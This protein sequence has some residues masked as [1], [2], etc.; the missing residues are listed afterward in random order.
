MPVLA[1]PVASLPER[2]AR[3]SWARSR[4]VG[5]LLM[6]RPTPPFTV[7]S[8][9]SSPSNTASSSSTGI[10]T[11]P[12]IA[13]VP[14]SSAD[15]LLGLDAN[16]STPHNERRKNLASRFVDI[17]MSPRKLAGQPTGRTLAT[18][19]Q[20]CPPRNNC[21]PHRART[22]S[23][24]DDRLGSPKQNGPRRETRAVPNDTSEGQL[25]PGTGTTLR[26]LAR[27]RV[28]VH[29]ARAS[30]R[31]LLVRLARR[32]I[33]GEDCSVVERD[34]HAAAG[35]PVSVVLE[36]E[37]LEIRDRQIAEGEEVARREGPRRE[38]Q[39]ERAAEIAGPHR[40]VGR[41]D[42][43]GGPDV[44]SK[45]RIRRIHEEEVEILHVDG[46]AR[47]SA[48]RERLDRELPEAAHLRE[49]AHRGRGDGP[50]EGGH[51]GAVASETDRRRRL[52][53]PLVEL[54]GRE[55]ARTARSLQREGGHCRYVRRGG[56]RAEEVGEPVA[57]AVAARREEG[58]V[59]AV[60]ARD[61]RRRA[62]FRM[63]QAV[64]GRVEEDG[65]RAGGAEILREVG[66]G[67]VHRRD[68]LPALGGGVT[69]DC[70][71]VLALALAE[72]VD[73][74]VLEVARGPLVHLGDDDLEVA[75]VHRE[76]LDRFV[77]RDVVVQ[78][79]ECVAVDVVRIDEV[80]LRVEDED[81]VVGPHLAEVERL[82][83]LEVA[84]VAEERGQLL[85]DAD[86][87]VGVLEIVERDRV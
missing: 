50:R 13:V 67:V 52:L 85:R 65:G 15:T 38:R 58:G 70:R 40:D 53:Q 49:I 27:G 39:R 57:I 7:T 68:G 36:R 33:A 42:P 5:A 66:D 59:A 23:G 61:L 20:N 47:D 30:E 54:L 63:V 74:D 18:S 12:P 83:P 2:A 80:A 77:R 35:E 72:A 81:V 4:P 26:H 87:A 41:R 84:D 51:D 19:A 28:R 11:R 56:A 46:D 10:T 24:S 76:E 43:A 14:G 55:A 86:A 69:P 37:R 1:R 71:R 16:V 78:G 34:R 22:A 21:V 29:K 31:V 44:E 75:R 48:V 79:L 60:D 9:S 32:E 64:A 8:P 73:D 82:V 17:C 25:L 3:M 45:G 62:D 6:P